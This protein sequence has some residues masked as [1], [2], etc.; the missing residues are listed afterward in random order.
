MPE[1]SDGLEDWKVAI[2]TLREA[3]VRGRSVSPHPYDEREK[4]WVQEGP[5]LREN[6]EVDWAALDTVK[7]E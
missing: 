6:G 7:G 3:A 5:K 2:A 4:K 1:I